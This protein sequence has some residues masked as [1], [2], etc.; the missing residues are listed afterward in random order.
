VSPFEKLNKAVEQARI[1]MSS[2]RD[3]FQRHICEHLC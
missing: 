3:E 1:E 2:A